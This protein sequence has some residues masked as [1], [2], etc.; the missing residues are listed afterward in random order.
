MSQLSTHHACEVLIRELIVCSSDPQSPGK[1][2]R[3]TAAEQHLEGLLD[4]EV[5]LMIHCTRVQGREHHFTS[6]NGYF[7]FLKPDP[8]VLGRGYNTL[9]GILAG[10][11]TFMSL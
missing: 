10:T 5:E 11:E 3:A 4:F 8:N 7:P 1:L 6:P 9:R 2:E